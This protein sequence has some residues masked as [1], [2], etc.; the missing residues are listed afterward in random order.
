MKHQQ[1]HNLAS[2]RLAF[3][4][5]PVIDIGPLMDGSNPQQVAEELAFVCENIGFLYIKNHGISQDLIDQVYDHAKAFFD[6]P[7]TEKMRLNI[8]QSGPTLRGYIPFYT[9]NVDPEFT[10]DH[11]EA[12]DFAENNNTSGPFKGA[13]VMPK[14]AAEFTATMDAYYSAMLGLARKLIEGIALSLELN[15][16]FFD[17]RLQDPITIQRLLHYPPQNENTLELTEMGIGAHTD[18]G[19][20]TILH[21]DQTGGLQVQNHVGDWVDAPPIP[22]TFVI[23]IGD[24][25]ETLTNGRYISTV[26]RVINT[27]GSERYSIPF[28]ID[29]DYNAKVEPVPTCQYPYN[30]KAYP[31]FT[32]G[33]YKYRRTVE[34]FPHLQN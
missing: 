24:L 8:T 11:K 5:I 16:N 26:H 17:S 27:S 15:A 1:R 31:C 10:K 6:Q 2:T 19:F 12:F 13:N 20:V 18:Y 21:Q 34:T 3:E 22:G 14:Q 7:L 29:M 28:F 23:N 9:E 25:V 4:D 32:C 33:D 30:D